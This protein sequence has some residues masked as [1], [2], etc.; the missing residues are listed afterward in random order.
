MTINAFSM[1]AWAAGMNMSL[2]MMRHGIVKS[3]GPDVDK[4]L[5]TLAT[6][7]RATAS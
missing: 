7:A 2:G 6:S 1:G 4:I 3:I 5:S